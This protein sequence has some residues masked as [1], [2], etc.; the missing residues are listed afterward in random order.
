M[1]AVGLSAKTESATRTR[2]IGGMDQHQFDDPADDAVGPSAAVA[3]DD[4]E[5]DAEEQ[6]D[7]DRDQGVRPARARCRSSS[8]LSTSRP[9]VSVPSQWL[10]GG[11][12]EHVV[13][14]CSAGSYGASTGAED[15]GQHQQDQVGGCSDA[16][17]LVP[18]GPPH[19][20]RAGACDGGAGVSAVSM[21]ADVC[22]HVSRTLGLK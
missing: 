16:H 21:C 7:H 15:A 20:V 10:A 8:R 4:A 18:E 14:S 11:P 19:P 13:R 22:G 9:R 17:R 2:M 3:G 6:E 5:R 12:A 1:A